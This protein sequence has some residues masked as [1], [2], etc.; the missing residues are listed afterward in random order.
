VSLYGVSSTDFRFAMDMGYSIL[1]D[2]V[3][4][5]WFIEFSAKTL[6]VEDREWLEEFYY[7]L[8]KD[9][10]KNMI[11]AVVIKG[12]N[13]KDCVVTASWTGKFH[14]YNIK[15]EYFNTIADAEDFLINN[16]N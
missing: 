14:D 15:G 4:S 5:N 2:K 9:M 13:F 3:N 1:C 11:C 8:M 10:N 12:D 16:R 6:L 7:N